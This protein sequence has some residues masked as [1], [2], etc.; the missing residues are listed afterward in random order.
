MKT[1]QI[2]QWSSIVVL[3]YFLISSIG[4][5]GAGFKLATGSFA[6]ELLIFANNPFAGLMVGILVTSLVQSSS[7][8]TSLVVGL[9]MGGLPINIAIPLVFGANIGTSITSTLVSLNF[10]KKEFKRAFQA[11]TVHDFFNLLAVLLI[12]PLEMAT[13]F[14]E[15]TSL[16]IAGLLDGAPLGFN[17]K[18]FNFIKIATKPMTNLLKDSVS[19]VPHP[20][21]GLSLILVGAV[22][23]FVS[24]LLTAKLLKRL[25][26]GRVKDL[27][28]NAVE[29]KPATSIL[30]GTLATILVQSSSTTTSLI[31]PFASQGLVKLKS[32]YTFILGANI[33]TCVTALLAASGAQMN[34]TAAMQ[35]ALVHLLFNIS[36]II[37]VYG[38][39]TLRNI[40]IILAKGLS[41]VAE[42]KKYLA[43]AYLASAFFVVPALFLAISS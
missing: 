20:F 38:I 13:H 15:K 42:K 24:I 25:M 34:G 31:V 4:L 23:V 33:G 26:V 1:K 12:F 41:E 16:A 40:P 35:I 22:I 27:F 36:G 14:L 6:K 19:W 3:L 29:T 43:L 11:A 18:D 39:P 30:T 8:V 37:I 2:A 5:V 21:D 7:T 9:V 10:S 17:I 28:V 32:V